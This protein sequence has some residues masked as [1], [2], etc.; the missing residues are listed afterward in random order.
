MIQDERVGVSPLFMVGGQYR[1]RRF[2]VFGQATAKPDAEKFPA[3]QRPA[4]QLHY[5]FGLRY[6]VG[7]AI[8]R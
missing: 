3:L 2:S 1:M 6:N 5:E 8:D 4:V 7:S